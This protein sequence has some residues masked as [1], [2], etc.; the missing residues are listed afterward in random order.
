MKKTGEIF[1]ARSPKWK[2]NLT[3][4][5][6]HVEYGETAV[7]A[8]KREIKEETNL[9]ITDIEFLT[10]VEII[11]SSEAAADYKRHLFCLDYKVSLAD[12]NQEPQLDGVENTEYLWLK[13]EDIIKRDDVEKTVKSTVA[14]Y[15]VKHKKSLF[16]V[17][18]CKDC[19]KMKTE[20]EEY[21]SGWQRALADYKNLQ[22]ETTSRMGEWAQMSERQILEEFIPV[23]DN[24]KKAFVHHPELQTD[25]EEHKQM[26]NWTDG[27][28]YIMKQF[29]EVLKNH[30]IE[31]I[32]TVGEK[33]DT[34]YHEAAGE[35]ESES[36]KSGIITKEVDGGYKM[37]ERVIK[38]AKVIIS[39]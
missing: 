7:E 33:L 31:E 21:K 29:G 23:Y 11:E 19:E 10:S 30:S 13:P 3:I 35:E 8:L 17:K 6:G 27:I 38:P 25:N 1:L 37:G 34:R 28:G 5:G 32:K 9:D 24:F 22:K 20:A 16:S 4:P 15:F 18:K 2:N 39:K 26:K 36:Q 12:E 14:E